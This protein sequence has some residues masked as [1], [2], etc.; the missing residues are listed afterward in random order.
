ME[1]R[2][3]AQTFRLLGLVPSRR[4]DADVLLAGRE[5]ACGS[6]FPASVKE[7][8]SLEGAAELF[9]RS[10][11]ERMSP[12]EALG[13]PGQVAQGYLRVASENQGVVD[14]YVP[15]GGPDD[16]P[17]LVVDGDR[18]GPLVAA[19]LQ[20]HAASFGTFL[21]DMFAENRFRG[22]QLGTYL[23]ARGQAPDEAVLAELRAHLEEGPRTDLRHRKIRRLF[24]GAGWLTAV[25]ADDDLPAHLATWTFDA[26]S[27]EALH[28]MVRV[29]WRLPGLADTIRPEGRRSA[30][31]AGVIARL[32]REGGPS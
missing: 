18:K 15:L 22:W 1:L 16:P 25:S 26:A 5:S 2:Y 13:S 31:A 32:R 21:F 20:I 6:A 23:V 27:P 4:P 12:L 29:L 28:D 19:S 30:V 10:T 24:G 3:H 7:W 9:S 17:V 14:W 11:Q 8:F